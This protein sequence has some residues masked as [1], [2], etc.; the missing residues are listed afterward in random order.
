MWR[1]ARSGGV[2]AGLVLEPGCGSG[3]FMALAPPGVRMVGVEIDP[4]TARE[5][6]LRWAHILGAVRLPAGAFGR[7]AGTDVVADVLVLRRRAPDELITTSELGTWLDAVPVPGE[8]LEGRPVCVSGY[9][10]TNPDKVLGKLAVTRDMFGS[11]TS[12][13]IG[14]TTGDVL[15]GQLE[16]ALAVVLSS[17]PAPPAQIPNRRP[18]RERRTVRD[19][20]R[21]RGR[22]VCMILHPGMGEGP[23]RLI[24]SRAAIH[25]PVECPNSCSRTNTRPIAR[26]WMLQRLLFTYQRCR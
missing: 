13:V 19:T 6:I 26:A 12:T 4:I 21:T 20:P 11:P 18:C 23:S 10:Q 9:W 3:T 17:T 7:V 22:L 25:A 24:V 14:D 8:D 5:Q 15:A 16:D 1:A 2:D